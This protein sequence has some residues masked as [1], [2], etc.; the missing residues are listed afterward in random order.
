MERDR[1][2]EEDM[3]RRAW[4]TK[5]GSRDVADLTSGANR[6]SGYL[7]G[8][9]WPEKYHPVHNPHWKRQMKAYAALPG[10]KVLNDPSESSRS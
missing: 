3:R 9:G 7:C 5:I 4:N 1:Q 10:G 6:A 8:K 2:I